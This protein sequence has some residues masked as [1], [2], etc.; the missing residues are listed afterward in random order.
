MNGLRKA[1]CFL[2]N[3]KPICFLLVAFV[4]VAMSEIVLAQT[5]SPIEVNA[6]SLDWGTVAA[7]LVGALTEVAVVGLGIAVSLWVLFLIA[8]VFKRS[9]T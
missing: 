5:T 2:S 1:G 9:A 6:P 4:F 3:V 7:D 8:K